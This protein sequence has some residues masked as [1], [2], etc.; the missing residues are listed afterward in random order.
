MPTSS[1]DELRG[2]ISAG[3]YAIDSG[4]VAGEILTKFAL[5]RRVTRQLMQEDDAPASRGPGGRRQRSP[6]TSEKNLTDRS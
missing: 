4:E 5:V 3:Q 6:G 2:Q 1:L